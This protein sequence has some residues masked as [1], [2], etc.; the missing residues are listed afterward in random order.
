MVLSGDKYMKFNIIG[1]MEKSNVYVFNMTTHYVP[2]QNEEL[3][4][5][6]EVFVVKYVRYKLSSGDFNAQNVQLG[7]AYK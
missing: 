5:C 7:L 6:G 2:R 3:E 1:V 4:I